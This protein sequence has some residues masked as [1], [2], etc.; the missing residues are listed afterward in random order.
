ML[1]PALTL[2]TLAFALFFVLQN[3]DLPSQEETEK[4]KEVRK[5]AYLQGHKSGIFRQWQK[6]ER[7]KAGIPEPSQGG[8]PW[9]KF[10]AV[11]KAS[12]EAAYKQFVRRDA[13][14]LLGGG[15]N[16]RKKRQEKGSECSPD[17]GKRK[18]AWRRRTGGWLQPVRDV[19]DPTRRPKK[20]ACRGSSRAQQPQP[21]NSPKQRTQK[22]I[23]RRRRWKHIWG[24]TDDDEL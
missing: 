12:K 19:I 15:T 10:S 9:K 4:Q 14:G 8:P 2:G 11:R 22:F 6:E 7:E 20:D 13:P 16:R 21:R 23:R 3:V 1:V 24:R 18:S 17:S 5:N